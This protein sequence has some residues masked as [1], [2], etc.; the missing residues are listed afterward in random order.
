MSLRRTTGPLERR[1]DPP[2]AL[3]LVVLGVLVAS[4]FPALAC[5]PGEIDEAVFAGAVTHYDLFDLSPQAPGYPLWIL[6]GRVLLPLCVTPFNALATAATLLSALA[7]PALYVWG[8][9]TVGGWA[10]LGGTLFAAALPVVWVNGG[11]AFSDAPAT[12]FCLVAA[13]LLALSDERRVWNMTRWREY[14]AARRGRLR[15]VLA[16][17]AAAAGFGV[18]PHLILGFGLLFLVMSGRL[19][20]RADRR[21]AALSFLGAALA[22][23][24]AWSLWLLAQAGGLS[25]LWATVAERA[26]FRA[27]AMA[28]GSVG[29]FLDSFLVRDLLSPRRALVFWLV[30]GVGVA[31]L[32]RRRSRG[33]LDLLLLLVP[34]FL[35]L[36]LLHTRSM[37]RYSVPFALAASLLFASG[38]ETLLR[39]RVLGFAAAAG[40]AALFAAES[41]PEVRRSA[42]ETT[43]PMAA[44]EYLERWVHPGRDTIIADEP[45][46]AFLRTEIREGRLAAWGF[47]DTDFVSGYVASNERLVRLSDFTGDADRP[48]LADPLWHTWSRGGRVAERLGNGRLLAV[49]VRDPS[50]PLF[51]PGFGVK[52]EPPGR[53]AFHWA[54]PEARLVV[55][56]LEGPPVAIL[57]GER[58]AESGPTTLRVTDAATGEVIESRTVN[59]GA[60]DL[61]IVPRTIYGPLS[62]PVCWILSCDRP[63]A[64]PKLPGGERPLLGCFTFRDTAFSVPPEALWSRRGDRFDVDLGMPSDRSVDLAGFYAR[65]RIGADGVAMRWTSGEA[66]AAFSPVPGFAPVRL[67]LRLKSPSDESFSVQ[68]KVGGVPCGEATVPAGD[69]CERSFELPP[70]AREAFQGDDPVRIVLT[71]PTWTP[72][73]GGGG[74]DPRPLGVGVARI[75]LE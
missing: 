24:L 26:D 53:P 43:P 58:D 51:G 4:R 5:S 45:F 1:G 70:A 30:A 68:V 63:R 39:R 36:W 7:L 48:D 40:A 69:F 32:V 14:V 15:A 8:R 6:I 50:P 67:V 75:S 23:S 60:F 31:A 16:G 46:H 3:V 10:A 37:S 72:R 21:D 28:T 19:L 27:L 52:E 44:I 12:A 57:S 65:E 13:A 20:L 29:G 41:W 54:G 2:L 22:G 9:R 71:S 33:A 35:S 34:L 59:P 11:R 17:L 56:G 74:D 49:G 47:T 38:L 42:T 64:L 18:R 55:P 62:Q 25:G 66:S 73:E 61:A